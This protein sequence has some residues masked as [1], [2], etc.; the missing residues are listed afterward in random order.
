[1][2]SITSSEVFC[3]TCNDTPSSIIIAEKG[4]ILETRL[5]LRGSDY[6]TAGSH[7][8]YEKRHA[9]ILRCGDCGEE[10]KN[11]RTHEIPAGVDLHLNSFQFAV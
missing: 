8:M 4:V 7:K 5:R 9:K 3:P 11:N 1:M 2:L 6:E 10:I